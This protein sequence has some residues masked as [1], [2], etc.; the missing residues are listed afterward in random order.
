MDMH[1]CSNCDSENRAEARFCK[2]CGVWLLPNCPFCNTIL[3]SA[4]IFCD[5]CG[6]QLNTQMGSPP[7]V[8]EARPPSLSVTSHSQQEGPAISRSSFPHNESKPL[9]PPTVL[10]ASELRQYIPEELMKKLQAARDQG[11]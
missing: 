5:R 11:I 9:P 7:P 6:R 8:P 1:R 3:P 10:G 4:A 2:R